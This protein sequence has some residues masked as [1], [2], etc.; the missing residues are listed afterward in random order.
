LIVVR[1]KRTSDESALITCP[2]TYAVRDNLAV[3]LPFP[4]PPLKDAQKVAKTIFGGFRDGPQLYCKMTGISG[5][6]KVLQPQHTWEQL[7]DDDRLIEIGF[8]QG[9]SLAL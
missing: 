6:I 8:F 5:W 3:F 2:Q 9:I 4:D 7:K 1:A